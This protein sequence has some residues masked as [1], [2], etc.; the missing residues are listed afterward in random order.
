[1]EAEAEKSRIREET[2]VGVEVSKD[3]GLVTTVYECKMPHVGF[4]PL[5][6]LSYHAQVGLS[7]RQLKLAG[8]F[9][10]E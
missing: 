9:C 3:G 5:E 7:Y 1:M 8:K 2:A 10:I 6:I 4:W